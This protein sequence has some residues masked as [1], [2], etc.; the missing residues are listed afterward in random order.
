[1]LFSNHC[2]K[3]QRSFLCQKIKCKGERQWQMTLGKQGQTLHITESQNN[4]HLWPSRDMILWALLVCEMQLGTHCFFMRA[5]LLGNLHGFWETSGFCFEPSSLF[6]FFQAY[7]ARL[8]EMDS[9]MTSYL[10]ISK[11]EVSL[12]VT[13]ENTAPFAEIIL[14]KQLVLRWCLELHH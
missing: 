11:T 8:A 6:F 13:L 3:T 14:L 4:S 2:D 9:H 12:S 7:S 10:G 5:F 1:M